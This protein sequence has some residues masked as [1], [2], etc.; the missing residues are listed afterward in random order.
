VTGGLVVTPEGV[1][2]L[3]VVVEGERIRELVPPGRRTRRT[4][5]ATGCYV[6]PGGVDP[7][8]HVLADVGSSTSAAALGG[9]TTVISFTLPQPGEAPAQALVRARD[10]LVPSSFVDVALHAYVAAPDRL[11]GEDV[12]AA[13]A[14]GATGVKLFTAYQELGLQASD[15][16]VF[17]TLRAADAVGL[18]VLVHCENGDLVAALVERLRREGRR[19]AAAFAA[20]RPPE[21]EE[22]AVGRVL[23]IA[24]LAGGRVYI[25][26]VTTRG[27]VE[28]IRGARR[29]GARVTGEACTHHLVLDAS[30]YEGDGAADALVVPPLRPPE[31]V[32]AVWA[33]LREGALA[34]V[35]SDHSPH[36][37][38]PPETDDFTG[39]P[40]GFAG[41]GP[42][43]PLLLSF[44]RKRGLSLERICELAC[45]APAR[46]FGLAP[47]KGAIVPGADADLVVWD[48]TATAVLE[49]APFAG[50]ALEGRVRSVLARGA[51]IVRDGALTG[52]PAG[53]FVQPGQPAL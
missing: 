34:T 11:S 42:R 32:E 15:R 21:V 14:E 52:K 2:P 4:V 18:P 33:A 35:G 17:E 46:T 30:A 29:R 16:V 24:S 22:E 51:E 10:E 31:H 48:P 5:D 45:T 40:Y 37:Y 6:L 50:L 43:L 41:V 13:A 23:V 9:T 49:H 7:H 12:A 44:G 38:Q 53:R 28:A 36:P 1:R 26:H 47:R 3:D 27:G 19:D 39:L 20:S 25:V 8:T